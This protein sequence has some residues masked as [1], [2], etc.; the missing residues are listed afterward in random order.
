MTNGGVVHHGSVVLLHRLSMSDLIHLDLLEVVLY[1]LLIKIIVSSSNTSI[2]V[3][4]LLPVVNTVLFAA[5][6]LL[7]Q[8]PFA[9]PALGLVFAHVHIHVHRDAHHLLRRALPTEPH[10][11]RA[12]GRCSESVERAAD[13]A[14]V[15]EGRGCESTFLILRIELDGKLIL[16]PKVLAHVRSAG[17][18]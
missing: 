1:V 16:N 6:P 5:F 17:E 18:L 8:A 9:L 12:R 11:P 13:H 7:Y 2:S 4:P 10:L 14:L 15:V 3:R